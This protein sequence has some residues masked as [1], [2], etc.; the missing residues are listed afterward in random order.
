[1]HYPRTLPGG[2]ISRVTFTLST[3]VKKQIKNKNTGVTS[4]LNAVFVAAL[5]QL[6]STLQTRKKIRPVHQQH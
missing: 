1:M 3:D 4:N 6:K 5:S 2:G